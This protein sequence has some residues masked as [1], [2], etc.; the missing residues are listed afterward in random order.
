MPIT[1]WD[2][3]EEV[4][5]EEGVKEI[6]RPTVGDDPNW[7]RRR[8]LSEQVRVYLCGAGFEDLGRESA[9]GGVYPG[10]YVDNY[11]RLQELRDHV[12]YGVR[13]LRKSGF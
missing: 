4:A 6:G 8:D 7:S 12:R 13:A 11:A 2:I 10:V 5:Q 9:D 1:V 3:I